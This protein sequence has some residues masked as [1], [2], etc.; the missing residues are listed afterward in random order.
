[1]TGAVKKI[2]NGFVIACKGKNL[3]KTLEKV[4]KMNG[5]NL[6]ENSFD[7]YPEYEKEVEIDTCAQCYD[8]ITNNHSCY[9]VNGHL[10]HEDC[11]Y[12][13]MEQFKM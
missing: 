5:A 7:F 12:E 4:L 9:L 3:R 2:N 1:M 11:L 10:I 13:Y 8:P 6:P